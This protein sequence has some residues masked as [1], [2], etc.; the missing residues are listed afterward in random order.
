VSD[1]QDISGASAADIDLLL[2]GIE[3]DE[4]AP[5]QLETALTPVQPSPVVGDAAAGT[6][7]SVA[8]PRVTAPHTPRSVEPKATPREPFAWGRWMLWWVPTLAVPALGGLA[9]WLALRST[10][11]RAARAMLMTGL[12]V[13]ALAGVLFAV[14]ATQ[15][16]GFVTGATRSTVIILPPKDA[17]SGTTTPGDTSPSGAGSS[18]Q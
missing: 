2:D 16:A 6:P 17:P 14:Y 11:A 15:I 4:S 9:A 7:Q 12:L 10:R 1:T 13:G 5:G 18:S 8:A 3:I